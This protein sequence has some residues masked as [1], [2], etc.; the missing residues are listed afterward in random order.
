MGIKGLLKQ[1]LGLFK[2]KVTFQQLK[3][4]EQIY[5]YA[6]DVPQNG[7]YRKFVGLS[8]SQANLQHIKFDIT[9]EIPLGDSTV[10]IYQ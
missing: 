9:Q 5:L 10:D 3:T 6:G 8:L 2:D 4:K 7:L 1:V